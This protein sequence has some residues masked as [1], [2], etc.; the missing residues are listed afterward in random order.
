[1]GGVYFEWYKNM[2]NTQNAKDPAY[3]DLNP[4]GGS[5]QEG[6]LFYFVFAWGV[7]RVR[8]EEKEN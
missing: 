8:E 7:R 1:V 6:F 2:E 3:C 4:V 5:R